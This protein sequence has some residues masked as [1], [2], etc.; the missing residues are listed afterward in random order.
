MAFTFERYVEK[1]DAFLK[2]VAEAL[3]DPNDMD[4]AYRVFRAVTHAIRDNITPEENL[5]L[6][7]QLPMMIKAIYIDNWKITDDNIRHR[8]AFIARV[9]QYNTTNNQRDLHTPDQTGDAIQKVFGILKKHVSKGEIED[10]LSMMPK[11][12]Q[13]LMG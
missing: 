7:S 13:P 5:H 3:G 11:E 9:Q 2:E 1:S 10:V 4:K 8:D 12:V 6:I